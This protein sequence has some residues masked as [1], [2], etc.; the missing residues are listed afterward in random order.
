MRGNAII[1]FI[2]GCLA[3][4]FSI[5]ALA[6]KSAKK[7][8]YL[9]VIVCDVFVVAFSIGVWASWYA[10]QNNQRTELQSPTVG[11]LATSPPAYGYGY[12]LMVTTFCVAVVAIIFC[13]FA[14]SSIEDEE[15]ES[16]EQQQRQQQQQQQKDDTVGQAT[17]TGDDVVDQ[18][19]PAV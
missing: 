4:I 12:G 16:D 19:N 9:F 8:M 2:F 6:Q 14:M 1:T 7:T 5:S 3:L 13:A 18:T 11:F 17:G 15:D 10:Q